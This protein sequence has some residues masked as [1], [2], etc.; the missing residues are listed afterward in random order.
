MAAKSESQEWFT[1]KQLAEWLG[2]SEMTLKAW[3]HF[4]TDGPAFT[5]VGR[6]VRYRRRDVERWL[7]A[8]RVEVAS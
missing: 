2:V 7:E 6:L 1:P 3:R 4:G 5:K 8:R